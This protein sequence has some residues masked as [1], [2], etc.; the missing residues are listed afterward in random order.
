MGDH[1]AARCRYGAKERMDP[2]TTAEGGR[3]G[4]SGSEATNLGDRHAD[5]VAALHRVA[6]LPP[7]D[8]DERLIQLVG[9][10]CR[11]LGV[12]RGF[13][14]LRAPVGLSVRIVAGPD[15]VG[16]AAG[17]TVSDWRL[18]DVLSRQATVATLGG[19]GANH[20]Q[21]PL[22]G[23]SMVACPLWVTGRVAGAIAF[24][25]ATARE[26]FS[27]W[28]LALVDLVADGVSR[29][30]EHEAD[31]RAMVRLESQAQAM[32][33]L[34]PD[35]VVRLRRDG[36]QLS[37]DGG[38]V[39][40]VFDP[41]AGARPAGTPADPATLQLVQQAVAAALDTGRLQTDVY[42]AG[43]GL[44]ARR[45]EARFVPGDGDVV[46]C[47]VRDITE[48]HRAELALAEQVAFEAL[49]ASIS[50][51][52]IGCAPLLLDDAIEVGLGEIASFFGAD[53][54]FIDELAP[55][56]STLRVSH[57]WS[58]RSTVPTR[59]RG[60]KV[61]V[62]GFGWLTARF[63]RAGHVFVRGPGT[64]PRE[65]TEQALVDADDKGVLWVRLGYGGELVGVLGLTW[66]THEP[67]PSDEVLGLVRFAADAFLGALR[68][69]SVALL[70]DGQAEVFEL[71]A[72][73]APVATA[74]IAARALLERHTLGA[75]VVIATVEEEGRLSLVTESDEPDEE[76]LAAWFA[77]LEPG[78]GNPFGQAVITGEPVMVANALGD[79]RY[80][81][82]VLPDDSWRS[83]TILPVRSPRNGRTLALVGLLA[84]EPGAPI[85]RPAVRDS[86]LSLVT[87]AVERD[88]D[89]RRLAHQATHD[90]LTGVGNR[91]ALLDRL[92]LAL[93]RARR[94]GRN[95]AVLFCDLDGFKSV[96][97]R[98][99]HDRGDR[100][101]VEV[102][103][104][105]G[106]AVRPSDTV[107]RTGG[108][109]FVIVC[110]DL[111]DADQA[112]TIAAR[113]RSVVEGSAVD[114]GERHLHVTVSVGVALA[115][116]PADDPD[117]LLRTADLAMYAHK[118]ARAAG[119]G[120]AEVVVADLSGDGDVASDAAGGAEPHLRAPGAHP[121]AQRTD[122]F[123]IDL[124]E[125]IEGDRLHLVHQPLVGRDGS[126][127]GIEALVRWNHPVLGAVGP[128]R[129][130]SAAANDDLAGPLGRWVRRA[131]LADRRRWLGHLGPAAPVP[132]HLNL[133]EAE[134]ALPHLTDALLGELE[135]AGVGP[136]AV[137]LEIRERH[138]AD[139]DL[140]AVV[141]T[142][143]RAG[144]AVLVE[145]AGQGGLSL[146]ELATLPVRGLK[147]G[148]ALV[149]QISLD[150]PAG[151]EVARSLV[152]L[153]HGL[154]WRSL[155]VGVETE[156][157]R[158][159]LFGFGVEAVQGKVATMP[160]DRDDLL[161]WLDHRSSA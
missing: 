88:I 142:L 148:P 102:A 19:P 12:G 130:L 57:Q 25:G 127:A 126:L 70:A 5:D 14:L 3:V 91:A 59:V 16:P 99:G 87:V 33:D 146:G 138:L 151:V 63:E 150:E 72:R 55:D 86:V 94:S 155:A 56:G 129:I 62:K 73:G 78:L 75:K 104:R 123:G 115:D 28:Q 43:P 90:P 64:I 68:R 147:L 85:A 34:M 38:H 89:E 158:A 8:P 106:R 131:A 93:A 143:A 109:E 156:H 140:R 144:L 105:I 67:P 117:R 141:A 23:G 113:V 80:T 152:I 125:A 112:H 101:L 21:A 9:A 122:P 11:A 92:T 61:D 83:A 17:D 139:P 110:E 154:G 84:A 128:I 97:D 149:G 29:V 1:N 82:P 48:R 71:I 153:A 132:V 4:A 160:L 6:S 15:P 36:Q 42:A 137:V 111:T 24:T 35:P 69:R 10:G 120:G 119:E 47:I 44:D 159:V 32:I 77:A 45:V 81:H 96:N 27:S 37:D 18:D 51:R 49:V 40:G 161:A 134:L 66:R 65:A 7:G 2:D 26:P 133:S 103:E 74:I 107:C 136:D 124:A 157:Q 95:V 22:G 31:I 46:L 54:A 52:L 135:E 145:N 98:F 30:L 76:A 13:V 79:P 60:Q 100:L 114:V 58:R 121:V 50:T 108:D 116:L 53:T 118:Q 20:E 41:T 39:L